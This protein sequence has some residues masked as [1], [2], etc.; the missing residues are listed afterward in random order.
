[1]GDVWIIQH[2]DAES[3]ELIGD[4]LEEEGQRLRIIHTQ[5]EELPHEIPADCHGLVIMGGPMG[6]YEGGRYHWIIPEIALI[7]DALRAG[8]PLLGVCMG[9]QLLAS[10]AGAR[11]YPGERPK[12]IGWDRVRLT[13]QG[14][15]DDLCRHLTEDGG[16]E[17]TVF[18]WH[19]DTFDLPEGAQLLASSELY[20]HQAFRIGKRAY[21]FQFH[22]ELGARK[23]SE[24]LELW[25]EKLRA[26]GVNA[27]VVREQ[28]SEHM[29]AF[30]ARGRGLISAFASLLR[31]AAFAEP[32]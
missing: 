20:P 16:G 32:A 29:E 21:G 1:M 7:R 8:L 30:T 24:W 12:E 15:E 28:T 19:G 25:P 31:Q 10:A 3:P 2:L 5:R 13:G 27:Q 6:V 4:V 9:S 23:I 17:A 22:F 26:E 14:A 18:Q 11:V